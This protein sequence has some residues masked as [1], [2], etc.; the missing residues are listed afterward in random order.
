M[1]QDRPS[2]LSRAVRRIVGESGKSRSAFAAAADVDRATL[3][4][5]IDDDFEHPRDDTLSRIAIAGG[6]AW[7]ALIRIAEDGG[8]LPPKE[9]DGVQQILERLDELDERLRQ[10]EKR[11]DL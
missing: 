8:T 10:L 6:Y 4:R 11:R 5:Y 7:D 3:Q 1:T 9:N 2:P